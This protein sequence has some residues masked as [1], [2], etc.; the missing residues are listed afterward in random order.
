MSPL[1]MF[2][3]NRCCFSTLAKFSST[4]SK[5][6]SKDVGPVYAIW[7][8]SGGLLVTHRDDPVDSTKKT[9]LFD[10]A[11]GARIAS[12]PYLVDKQ[13]Y[14]CVDGAGDFYSFKKD[15]A[16]NQS[17]TFGNDYILDFQKHDGDDLTEI[18][19]ETWLPYT[20]PGPGIS[21]GSIAG[22]YMSFAR[23]VDRVLISNPGLRPVY[24][25]TDS[26]AAATAEA[27]AADRGSLA[28][29]DALDG[30]FSVLHRQFELFPSFYGNDSDTSTVPG[31]LSPASTRIAAR[32]GSHIYANQSRYFITVLNALVSGRGGVGA[33]STS[34]TSAATGLYY[35]PGERNVN[36]WLLETFATHNLDGSLNDLDPDPDLVMSGLPSFNLALAPD[37]TG[38]VILQN[39]RVGRQNAA[40]TVETR[41]PYLTRPDIGATELQPMSL[42]NVTNAAWMKWTTE[43]GTNPFGA[44]N[45]ILFDFSCGHWTPENKML[46]GLTAQ[47]WLSDVTEPEWLSQ[48]GN[49]FRFTSAGV[50]EFS[51]LF[52]RG[53]TGTAADVA[54]INAVAEDDDGDVYAGSDNVVKF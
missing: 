44:G 12:F 27:T 34:T 38:V 53:G 46:S 41:T 52:G 29:F 31:P 37:S 20:D 6:W 11:N 16:E 40:D 14:G 45:A 19:S 7:N 36:E 23:D 13:H 18:W 49:I 48:R 9:T 50:I 10:P 47:S 25:K 5:I 4:G 24:P 2:G 32:Y 35:E 17:Y 15:Q 28:E 39:R 8:V 30:A 3:C 22:R 1:F 43:D 51:A 33:W 54:R 42:V 26:P 21:V